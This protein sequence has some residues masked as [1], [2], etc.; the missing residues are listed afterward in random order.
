MSE[1]SH[2]AGVEVRD[3]KS[4]QVTPEPVVEVRDSEGV[5]ATARTPQGGIIHSREVEETD[6]VNVDGIGTMTVKQAIE[7]VGILARDG[8]RIVD[9]DLE[10]FEKAKAAKVEQELA[11]RKAAEAEEQE[12][13]GLSVPD[14]VNKDIGTI[15]SAVTEA[16]I[17]P[18]AAM[19]EIARDPS[20]LPEPV[21]EALS[22]KGL[23]HD[24]AL[25]RV[26]EIGA[27][28]EVAVEDM[29]I[30]QGFDPNRLSD[31]WA[32]ALEHHAARLP[33]AALNAI[34]RGT[35]RDYLEIARDFEKRR[36]TGK[37][38]NAKT[39]AVRNNETGAEKQYVQTRHGMVELEAAKKLGLA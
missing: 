3:N 37:P 5:L 22:A 15:A 36:G 2:D 35:G 8:A 1:Q 6:I 24:Q 4:I 12:T 7:H 33:G 30:E 27:E 10:A 19:S 9:V 31:F 28:I 13:F 29:L 21:V 17:N 38:H 16:G 14:D 25:S 20:K 39:E 23:D 34:Y 11:E 32:F 26:Q 18:M